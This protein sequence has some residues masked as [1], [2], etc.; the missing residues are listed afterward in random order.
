MDE[1]ELV[2]IQLVS[3]P[4]VEANLVQVNKQLSDWQSQ[5]TSSLPALVVLPECFAFFG[6]SEQAQ[7]SL[8]EHDMQARITKWC[9]ETAQQYGIW[10]VTGSIPTPSIE[11]NKLRATSWLVNPAGEICAEYNKVHLFDV[12]IADNTCAYRESATTLA[13]D[14]AVTYS[15]EIGHIG[16]A[17]CYDLRFS[18]LF[19][20]MSSKKPLDV[21][22][23]PA[24][25][26]YTTGKAH[27]H[28]L[29]SARA[30]E[31]QS[32]VVAANQGGLHANGRE[33]FGH[34]VIYSP[35]GELIALIEQ[36]NGW[37]SCHLDH[38]AQEHI[39]QAIPMAQHRKVF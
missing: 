8:L 11:S 5:R 28:N 15:G 16:M 21:I 23:L 17:I 7:L 4:D 34:T 13:G 2:A 18:A 20:A 14:Q 24:A 9:C 26:T 1:L 22:V 6:G 39:R 37:I 31:Y 35:W 19:N 33:T 27:W 3:V 25:F 36:G 30:I 32:Y 29:L 38:K 10:L 12:D